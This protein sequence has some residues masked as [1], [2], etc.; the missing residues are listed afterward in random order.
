MSFAVHDFYS[1]TLICDAK[2]FHKAEVVVLVDVMHSGAMLDR[3][4]LMCLDLHPARVRGLTL[5]DQ[6]GGKRLSASYLSVWRERQETRMSVEEFLQRT[7]EA[8]P[9]QL[10][11]FEPNDE[12]GVARQVTGLSAHDS[13]ANGPVA[14]FVEAELIEHVHA[15]GALKQDFVIAG[16]R[17]PYV[18]NVLDL[19]NDAGCR[20]FLL[21]RAKRELSCLRDRRVCLAYHAA[22]W[23]RAGA[24]AKA[25]SAE[26][27]WPLSP[28]GS[29]GA[30]FKLT[31]EQYR[32]LSCYD[33]VVIVDAAI[34]TGDTISAIV[35]A[36]DCEPLLKRPKFAAF[37]VLDALSIVSKSEL[38]EQLG[39]EIRTLFKLPLTPPTEEVRH[40]VAAQKA[41]NARPDFQM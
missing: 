13:S 15:T 36:L 3:L 10:E 30:S 14:A 20:E 39:I 23:Q 26:L 1:P 35:H 40:W 11:R 28:I 22:R 24:I 31:D 34:R 6:S 33:T 18:V 8:W 29:R 7:P 32:R 25:L 27:N 41:I 9:D 16:K 21:S 37:C 19:L 5:I 12:C 17:Y 38:A 4:L 2:E